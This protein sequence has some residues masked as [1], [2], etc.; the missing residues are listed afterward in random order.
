VGKRDPRV[1]AYIAQ[2]APFA[3]P[4]LRHLRELVHAACP[5]VVETIKWRSPFFDHHGPMCHMAAFKQHATFGFWKGELVAP[6]NAA[7]PAR[8]QFGR[9]TKVSEL[10]S[11]RQLTAYVREAMRLNEAGVPAPHVARRAAPKPPPVPPDDFLAALGKNAAARKHYRAFSPGQQREYVDWIVQ[12]R[13]EQ[14]R[15]QR[16]AQA[17]DW[18]AEGKARHWK[19][20]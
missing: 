3:A 14:T 20:L 1:D 17:V 2:A 10:P 19:Y 8:G 4:I 13:R 6:A 12:A 16:I 7:D 9:L 11:K 15:A 18:L 5:E